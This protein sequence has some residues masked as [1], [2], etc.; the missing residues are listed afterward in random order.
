MLTDLAGVATEERDV[1]LHPFKSYPLVL[2]TKVEGSS[3]YSLGS[4]REAKRPDAV[5]HRNK[6]DWG[7]LLM[8]SML[9]IGKG[10][11]LLR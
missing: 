10:S 1:I 5:V 11:I 3:R 9:R 7:S 4:L 8:R 6:N 2:Q